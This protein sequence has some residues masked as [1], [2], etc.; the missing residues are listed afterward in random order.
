MWLLL[1]LNNFGWHFTSSVLL[2]PSV[3]VHTHLNKST[4][5]RLEFIL[6]KALNQITLCYAVVRVKGVKFWSVL[7]ICSNA[8]YSIVLPTFETRFWKYFSVQSCLHSER[9]V[10]VFMSFTSPHKNSACACWIQR[11]GPTLTKPVPVHFVLLTWER[12]QASAMT[13]RQLTACH[14]TTL[15]LKKKV[16]VTLVQALRLCTGRTAHRRSRGI[17]LPF[18][19]H[20][21]RRGEGSA[22]RPGRSLP[23]GKTRYPLYRRLDGPQGRY[24]QA[25][26]ISPPPGFDPRTVQAVASHYTDWATQ[27]TPWSLN[28]S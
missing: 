6:R 16:K 20:S 28:L 17:A 8:V 5:L 1:N 27:P 22:S 11:I 7:F 13:G 23:P 26:K 24:G 18:H 25:R 21:T 2:E 3:Y 10:L 19:D 14:R 9:A 15:K 4:K 12:T